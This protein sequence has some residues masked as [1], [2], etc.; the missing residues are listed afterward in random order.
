LA[1]QAE[2]RTVVDAA[3]GRFRRVAFHES[4]PLGNCILWNSGWFWAGLTQDDLMEVAVVS[5]DRAYCVTPLALAWEHYRGEKT[6]LILQS[7]MIATGNLPPS[8]PN[9][10][11][12]LG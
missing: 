8:S 10:L 11:L 2:A 9:G 6:N 3:L 1:L 12:R 4:Y 5:Q 7:W